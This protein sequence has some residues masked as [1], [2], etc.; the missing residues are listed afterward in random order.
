MKDAYAL[1]HAEIIDAR[2]GGGT[3]L[4]CGANMGNK[5]DLLKREMD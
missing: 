5:Y 4:D 3:C 2:Q 1:S